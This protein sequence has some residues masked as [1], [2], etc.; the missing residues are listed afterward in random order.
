MD[1]IAQRQQMGP[2]T[3]KRLDK[4][5]TQQCFRFG[6]SGSVLCDGK[7]GVSAAFH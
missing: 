2:N 1:F 4:M 3:I 7:C 5:F 6:V